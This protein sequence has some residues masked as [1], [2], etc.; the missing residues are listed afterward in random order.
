MPNQTIFKPQNVDIVQTNVNVD[1]KKALFEA[2][3]QAIADQTNVSSAAIFTRLMQKEKDHTSAV[4]NGIAIP[5]CKLLHLTKPITLMMTLN[6]KIDFK[7]ADN[8]PVDLIYT[9]LSPHADAALHLQ[10]LSAVSRMLKDKNLVT[11]LREAQDPETL[12]NLLLS[13]NGWMIAA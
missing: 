12:Q 11:I 4:G 9:L 7:S 5:H 10:R 6:R 8:Q 13:P 2:I 1:T 3:S